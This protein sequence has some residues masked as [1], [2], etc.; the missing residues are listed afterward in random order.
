MP[1]PSSPGA[2]GTRPSSHPTTSTNVEIP[3]LL[4]GPGLPSHPSAPLLPS[5]SAHS[6]ASAQD[7]PGRSPQSLVLNRNASR[8]SVG[9][10]DGH[11]PGPLTCSSACFSSPRVSLLAR[12]GAVM[13]LTG[14]YRNTEDQMVTVPCGTSL[15]VAHTLFLPFSLFLSLCNSRSSPKPLA[16]QILNAVRFLTLVS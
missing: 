12:R 9:Q 15:R 8:P 4:P 2:S 1:H 7:G 3:E 10:P 13:V 5:R 14:R 11:K 6:R 16:T